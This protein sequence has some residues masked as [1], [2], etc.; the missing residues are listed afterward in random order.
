M[1]LVGLER[2]FRLTGSRLAPSIGL[3]RGMTRRNVAAG[4]RTGWGL[5]TQTNRLI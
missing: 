5:K 2:F 1:G 3:G 4:P